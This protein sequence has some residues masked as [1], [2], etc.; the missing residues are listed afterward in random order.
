VGV[1]VSADG[2][3]AV[4]SGHDH[5][6]RVWDPVRPGE[7]P[8]DSRRRCA[9]RR[10]QCLHHPSPGT[11]DGLLFAHFYTKVYDHVLR[12]LMA[13]DRPNAP[14]ELTAALHALDQL[15]AGH[16]ASARIPTAA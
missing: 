2:R 3:I 6:M 4:S 14:P 13:P 10:L 1:A 15:A 12:P 7:C 8:L 9:G 5:T 11:R 16:I